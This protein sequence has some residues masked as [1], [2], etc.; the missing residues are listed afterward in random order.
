MGKLV[1]LLITAF[2]DMVGL[3][4][5]LPLLPFYAEEL[6]ADAVIVGL[7]VSSASVTQLHRP[8]V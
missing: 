2:V 3:S 1:V 7:L 8:L 4:A 5:I 6:G